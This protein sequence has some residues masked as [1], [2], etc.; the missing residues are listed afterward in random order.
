MQHFASIFAV[1]LAQNYIY[2]LKKFNKQ[3]EMPRFFYLTIA[4]LLLRT[5]N[6]RLLM[7]CVYYKLSKCKYAIRQWTTKNNS[8]QNHRCKYALIIHSNEMWS[9]C[10]SECM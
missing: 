6:Q 9:R 10:A 8:K 3:Y 2:F 4:R 7:D 5:K 1:F